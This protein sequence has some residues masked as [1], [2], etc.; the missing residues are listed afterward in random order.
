MRK[1][2]DI[3]GE[4]NAKGSLAYRLAVRATKAGMNL[5][6]Y[7]EWLLEEDVKKG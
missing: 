2:I 4:L 7:I 1:L 5:K 6:A 3:V